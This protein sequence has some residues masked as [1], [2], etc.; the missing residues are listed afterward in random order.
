MKSFTAGKNEDG[1]RLSRFV[2]SVTTGLPTGLLY[3]S[4]RNR[5]IKVNGKRAAAD[6]RLQPGDLVELYINDEFSPKSPPLPPPAGFRRRRWSG[7]TRTWLFS[8]SPPTGSATPTAPA[9]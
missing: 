3:K 7:R 1:V 8:T 2:E 9:T 6:Y 4:F 5:R